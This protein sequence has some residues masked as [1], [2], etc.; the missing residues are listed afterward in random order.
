MNHQAARNY[1]S[2][3]QIARVIT[4]DWMQKEGYCPNCLNPSLT[5]YANNQP[6]ADFYCPRCHEDFELKSKKNKLSSMIPDGAYHTMLQRISS[7]NQ[8]N[9][10]FLTY[11][12]FWQVKELMLVPKYFFEPSIIIARQPLANHARRA[13]W[14]GCNIWLD[15]IPKAGRIHLIYEGKTIQP[16]SVQKKLQQTHFIHEKKPEKR[17]WILDIMACID[18]IPSMEFTLDKLYDFESELKQKHP[19]NRFIKDKIRQQLQLLRDKGFIEFLGHG[20]YR[21]TA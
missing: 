18:S 19:N 8:P 2:H 11:S 13:G 21:K 9:F 15:K 6:A 1:K 20:K 7:D 10:F 4:E 5:Q 16:D 12:A 17:V 14:V 3:A